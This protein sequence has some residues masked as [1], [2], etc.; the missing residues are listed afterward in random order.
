MAVVSCQISVFEF[1]VGME[2]K[3]DAFY[4]SSHSEVR[5]TNDCL[6]E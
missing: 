3:I 2:K 1:R 4:R 5:L 6:R